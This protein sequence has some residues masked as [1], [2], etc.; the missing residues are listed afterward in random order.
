[1]NAQ[2]PSARG[3]SD[4]A[5]TPW[6]QSA[7]FRAIVNQ[8]PQFVW[9]ATPDGYHDYFNDRWYEYTGMSREG[10][11]GWNWKDFLHPDDYDRTL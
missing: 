10:G 2:P 8:I 7:T 9:T 1:M 5:S 11:E 4:T 6:D 3:H